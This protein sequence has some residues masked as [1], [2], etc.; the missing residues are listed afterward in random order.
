[1][2]ER[3][4]L[5]IIAIDTSTQR[6]SVALLRGT[7]VVGELRL[8]SLETHSARLL[9][10]LD[11][12]L[13][14]AGWRLADIDLI[15]AGIGPGSFTGIRIGLSSA[16]GLAQSL[17]RP[18][19]PVSGLDAVAHQVSFLHMPVG[20]VL[21]AQRSQVYFAS[22]EC[23]PG[24]IRR[25]GRPQLWYPSAL[26]PR[27]SRK[28]MYLAGDAAEDVAP[29]ADSGR[30]GWPRCVPTDPFLASSIGRVA[31]ARK[32]IWRSGEYATAEP[33]YIRPPDAVK[34]KRRT[35]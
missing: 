4:L 20:V 17:S 10:S 18:L 16:L 22:Y 23:A 30:A 24:K 12:L 5:K 19:A 1:M 8:A 27:L 28:R 3:P 14:T 34:P 7:E 35:D 13:S 31:L 6:G 21:D 11:F 29:S 2:P 25:V 26:K 33:L 15:A 9:R 32:R